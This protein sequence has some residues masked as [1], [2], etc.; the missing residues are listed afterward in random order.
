[1]ETQT[2]EYEIVLP[3]STDW[4][5]RVQERAAMYMKKYE[6]CAQSVLASFMEEFGV[7]NPMVM[8]SAGA[9]HG[10]MQCSMTCGVY[11]AGLMI[12]GLI[13]G[14]EDLTQGV[15]GLAPI[16]MPGQ[17]LIRRLDS[18]LGSRSCL[19]ITGVD[20]NDLEQ[21]AKFY[22]S[23]DWEKCIDL[24]AN[25]AEEIGMFLKKLEENGE[26]YR[27]AKETEATGNYSI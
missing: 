2:K 3:E 4:I 14:R 15:D 19:E 24:V 26:L 17:D 6:S 22:E 13:I 8:R 20:M 21:V 10:G 18:R 25:G 12:L 1:M 11:T 27:I 7:D 9:M 5:V 16:F 23:G